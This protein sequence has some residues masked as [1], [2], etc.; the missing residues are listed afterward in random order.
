MFSKFIHVACIII[1]LLCKDEWII[2]FSAPTN[3]LDTFLDLSFLLGN[4]HV[5][6]S[7]GVSTHRKLYHFA[8]PPGFQNPPPCLFLFQAQTPNL[9]LKLL[10]FGS[11]YKYVIINNLCWSLQINPPN[12]VV[13]QYTSVILKPVDVWWYAKGRAM[14]LHNRGQPLLS[15]TQVR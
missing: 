10:P 4:A 9:K 5:C 6:F 8:L 12:N 3:V 13:K 1:S 15:Y 2:N 11:S 14:A 7:P